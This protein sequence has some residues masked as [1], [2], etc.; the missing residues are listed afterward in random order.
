MPPELFRGQQFSEKLDIYSFG[1]V[2]WELA[3]P[4][5]R[6]FEVLQLSAFVVFCLLYILMFVCAW[7]ELTPWMIPAAVCERNERPVV[8]PGSAP[9]PYLQLM[10]RCWDAAPAKR[11]TASEC[12][13][14]LMTI[15]REFD[16][17]IPSEPGAAATAATPRLAAGASPRLAA[18]V[19]TGAAVATSDAKR[20][21]S[22]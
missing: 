8:V 1:M 13:A 2:M 12:L 21:Q 14:T 22:L 6:P 16:V 17:P 20:R 11:P 10:R 9:E 19:A 3:S 18:G 5:R 4:G 15:A 7:Q